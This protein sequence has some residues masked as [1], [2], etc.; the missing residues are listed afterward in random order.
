MG[1]SRLKCDDDLLT[2]ESSHHVLFFR[3]LF[4]IRP[5]AR[6]KVAAFLCPELLYMESQAAVLSID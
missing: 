6:C 1:F 5:R 3:F 2:S 4:D